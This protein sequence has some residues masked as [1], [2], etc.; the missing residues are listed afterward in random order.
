[1][2]TPGLVA[3][4]IGRTAQGK[5]DPPPTRLTKGATLSPGATARSGRGSGSQAHCASD[6]QQTDATPP[7]WRPS[8]VLAA[9]GQ[10]FLGE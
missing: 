2:P 3:G 5:R 9:I 6:D 7:I 8:N 4:R 1:M 10:T